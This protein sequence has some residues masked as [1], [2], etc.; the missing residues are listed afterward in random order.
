MKYTHFFIFMGVLLLILNITQ[1]GGRICRDGL[2]SLGIS[3][4]RDRSLLVTKHN[5]SALNKALDAM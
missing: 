3:T 4:S 5:P 2:K 1:C